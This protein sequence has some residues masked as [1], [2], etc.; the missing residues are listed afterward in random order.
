MPVTVLKGRDVQDLAGVGAFPDE[1]TR[2]AWRDRAIATG[3]DPERAEF[4]CEHGTGLVAVLHGS[5]PGPVW[6]L[7]TD[8]DALPIAESDDV[9]HFPAA[10]GFNSID[11]V[12]HAC[13][14]DCH[15]AIGV[16]VLESLSDRDFPGTLKVI[17]QPA[18]EGVRGAQTM[19]NAGVA[20]DISRMLAVH[21]RGDS[22]VG[23]VIGSVSGGMATQKLRVRFTGRASHASGAPEQGR[24]ALL[25]AASS[26]LSIMALPRYSTADTRLNIGTLHAGDNVNIVPAN[27]TMTCEARADDDD[28]LLDLVAR[29]RGIIEGTAHAFGVEASIEVTGL[30]CTMQPDAELVQTIVDA[31]SGMDLVQ[32]VVATAPMFGS[33]DA[34]LLI[35]EVQRR[36]GLGA[37]INIGAG[38]PAPHHN[39]FFNPD[40]SCIPIAVDLIEKVIR[41]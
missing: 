27:A 25:A 3:L 41:S 23:T 22:P 35:R 30:A 20:D 33:D 32:A 6:G 13:G 1:P 34:H 8:I 19:L 21:V 37:Y 5:R 18:E 40:E 10:E 12:M 38:S 2:G 9:A 17:F 39:P 14:H 29:V 36:G 11:G 7:R 31:A 16:G 28:V 15:A 4:F 24:N 26:A